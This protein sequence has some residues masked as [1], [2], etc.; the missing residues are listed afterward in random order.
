M[1]NERA[2][3]EGGLARALDRFTDRLYRASSTAGMYDAALD[4]ISEA[5]D[6]TGASILRPDPDGVMRI[7][8]WRGLSDACRSAVDGYSPWLPDDQGAEPFFIEDVATEGL[9]PSLKDII[10]QEGLRS[11]AFIPVPMDDK[12]IGELIIGFER[13][14]AFT[15]HELQVSTTIT[16]QL[17]FCIGRRLADEAARWL[18]AVIESSDDAIFTK[19]LDG[20]ITGWNPGAEALFGYTASEVIGK[21]GKILIPIDRDDEE[22]T[23]FKR[24]LDGERIDHYETTRQRKDGS[25]VDISLSVSPIKDVDRV[26]IGISKIARDVTERRR[27]EEKQQLLFSEM[28]H[29]IKNLFAVASSIVNIGA[30]SATSPDDL[31]AAVC[32]RLNALAGA[33]SLTLSFSSP[34]RSFENPGTTLHSLVRTILSPFTRG[35]SAEASFTL[36]GPDVPVASHA[37]T[38]LALLLYEFATNAVKYG[39]LS[40]PG[41]HIDVHCRKGKDHYFL[42]WRENGGLPLS[43][44]N[45]EGFGSKLARATAAQLGAELSRDLSSGSLVIHLALPLDR[46]R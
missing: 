9:P 13:A 33:H 7:V 14:H 26:I 4:A 22:P 25:L 16:R 44:P 31:A 19:N 30:R 40:A 24:I 1:L 36:S 32:G 15:E 18:G 46:L 6:C 5:L 42:T 35:G 20:I 17:G 10:L 28:E 2:C 27:L 37:V 11:L 45:G 39:S 43:M 29:R 38:P 41:G 34:R 23:I 12:I 3:K 21:P 8:A